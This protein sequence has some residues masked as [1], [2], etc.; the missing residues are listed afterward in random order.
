MSWSANGEVTFDPARVAHLSSRLPGSVA[1]VFKQVNDSVKP[2]EIVALI[3]AAQVG[4]AKSQLLNAVVKR[5]LK[6]TTLER[7]KNHSISV[8]VS[9]LTEAEAA[10]QESEIAFLSARQALVNL[11]FEMADR[12]DGLDRTEV[13]GRHPLSG[14]SAVALGLPSR[15]HEDGEPFAVADSL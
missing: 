7:L 3:D 14:S 4:Q 9:T 2:G 11:G 8:P 10:F 6:R 5:E 15:R 1:A 12:F 13:G